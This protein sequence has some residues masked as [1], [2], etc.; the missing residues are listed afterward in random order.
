VLHA[1]ITARSPVLMGLRKPL[2]LGSLG[3][4]LYSQH[5]V[6]PQVLSY[7]VPLLIEEGFCT[8]SQRKPRVPTER[9]EFSLRDSKPEFSDGRDVS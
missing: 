8:V 2:A 1:L 4:A 7:V 9:E 3:E 5:H 6:T